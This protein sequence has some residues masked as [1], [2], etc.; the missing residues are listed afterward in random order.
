MST[1]TPLTILAM[2]KAFQGHIGVIQRNAIT[3]WTKLSPRPEIYL[4]GEEEGIAEIAAELQIHHLHDIARS[5]FGTPLLD[6][7]LRRARDFAQTPL[8]CYVNSDIMLL[9]EF[10]DGVTQIQA[11]FKKF[12]GVAHRLNVDLK[13][14]L[15]F[16]ADGERKLR[17]EI[18]PRG[19]PGNHTA[20]DVFVFPRDVY[21][22]VPPLALGRAW[23]DQ[24]LIKEARRQGIPVVDVTKVARA[25]HQE[26]DYGHIAGGQ[27]GAYWGEE[28]R[29]SL[30]LYGGVPHAFTLLDVTHELLRDG[31]IGRVRFRR[32][33]HVAREWFWRTFILR[34]ARVR[35]RLG[36][37]RARI[38][39]LGG[40]DSAAKV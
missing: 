19:L 12:L 16:A 24:W 40:K 39:R 23:F 1:A 32:A 21:Q 36:L 8:L 10:L 37:R 3:S 28:A 38:K 25:I 4:F 11:Q 5:D 27:K 14:P 30:A 34:T 31:R 15:D 2:P 29:R 7:L 17:S 9:Q 33:R 20:I 18:L 26:H 35:E 13:E 6:D 22:Q